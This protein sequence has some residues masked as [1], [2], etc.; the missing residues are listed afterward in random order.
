MVE[1]TFLVLY[2]NLKDTTHSV[3]EH[4]WPWKTL[5]QGILGLA[6]A[7]HSARFLLTVLVVTYTQKFMQWV[8]LLKEKK[9][10]KKVSWDQWIYIITDVANREIVLYLSAKQWSPWCRNLDAVVVIFQKSEKMRD[11]AK[12]T[13]KAIQFQNQMPSKAET[14]TARA[15]GIKRKVG[16]EV[17]QISY[18]A[19]THMKPEMKR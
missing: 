2:C 1:I 19:N 10:K 14:Q 4:R 16:R 18:E 17:T 8:C 15:L 5:I 11:H 3:V 9:K 13:M 6:F 12:N 7:L